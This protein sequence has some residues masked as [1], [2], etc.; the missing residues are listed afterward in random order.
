[1]QIYMQRGSKQMGQDVNNWWIWKKVLLEFLMQFM[2]L[3]HKFEIIS[4]YKVIPK[5]HPWKE[6][7]LPEN[8]MLLDKCL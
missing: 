2:Q 3:F 8:T 7:M 5:E 4:P 1:M 6:M